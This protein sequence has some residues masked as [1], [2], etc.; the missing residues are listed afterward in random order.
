M[1]NAGDGTPK[2][3]LIPLGTFEGGTTHVVI[4]RR[5]IDRA[6]E[7]FDAERRQR[8]ANE[9]KAKLRIA[10]A[11]RGKSRLKKALRLVFGRRGR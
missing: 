11:A 3:R 9:A 10:Q 7:V 6:N 1:N 4:P 5:A 8:E 2:G